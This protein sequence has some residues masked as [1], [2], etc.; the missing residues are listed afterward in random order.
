MDCHHESELPILQ[1]IHYLSERVE[2]IDSSVSQDVP[3]PQAE[4]M[5]QWLK[6]SNENVEN[7]VVFTTS[8]RA[9]DFDRSEN[10]A[11]ND[12]PAFIGPFIRDAAK[13]PQRCGLLVPE[14]LRYSVDLFPLFDAI[15]SFEI[16]G[17]QFNVFSQSLQNALLRKRAG[18]YCA[19]WTQ[20]CD[21]VV[22]RP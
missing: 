1:D 2:L 16:D 9:A 15:S 6:I 11:A 13:A 21:N 7:G 18:R 10:S 3:K 5:C 14:V 8:C 19:N 17:H 4:S 22:T 20:R 12:K